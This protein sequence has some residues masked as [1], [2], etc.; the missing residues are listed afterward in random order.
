MGQESTPF[1]ESEGGLCFECQ[2]NCAKCCKISGR[3]EI[4]DGDV[5]RMAEALNMSET[6]F[7]KRFVKVENGELLLEEKKGGPC[8]MLGEND[9]CMVYDVRPTQCRTYPF[10]DE[11]LAN[12]FTWLLEKDFC[13][14]IDQGGKFS[15]PE[16][17]QIRLGGG[18][19]SGYEA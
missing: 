14:G 9:Q 16:I 12:D 13:P 18:D 10:W 4:A 5:V 6:E 17:E 19:A 15:P 8:V 7:R 2:P 3:V 11:I 1:Y